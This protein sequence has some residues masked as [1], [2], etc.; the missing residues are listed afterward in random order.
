M[1]IKLKE[2]FDWLRSGTFNY[3]SNEYRDHKFNRTIDNIVNFIAQL[4]YLKLI[5]IPIATV[6]V[7]IEFGSIIVYVYAENFIHKL[8]GKNHK[9]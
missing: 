6:S 3:Y 2:G 9:R 5:G 4:P 7:L 1:K 8:K